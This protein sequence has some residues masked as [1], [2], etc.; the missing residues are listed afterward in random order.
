MN[1][2]PDNVTQATFP[3]LQGAYTL[4][5]DE[6]TVIVTEDGEYLTLV[7]GFTKR[8]WWSYTHPN[9]VRSE[10]K[11]FEFK[12]DKPYKH[13]TSEPGIEHT[14]MVPRDKVHFVRENGYSYPK[15][16]ING[17][18][19]TLNTSGGCGGKIKGWVDWIYPDGVSTLVDLD[20]ATVNAVAAVAITQPGIELPAN[21]ESV[22]VFCGL[23]Q[24]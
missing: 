16:W 22:F 20:K 13:W 19:I 17:Q 3:K 1:E 6:Y 4:I 7:F 5:P 11:M 23:A 12:H 9:L 21:T 2:L 18:V 14:F 10:E 8:E 15:L 24:P